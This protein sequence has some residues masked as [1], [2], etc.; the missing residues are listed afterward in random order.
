MHCRR[1]RR[2]LQLRSDDRLPFE[3]E[4]ALGVH[5]EACADCRAFEATLERIDETLARWPEPA[6]DRIDVDTALAAIHARIDA[7]APVAAAE[8]RPRRTAWLAA[9]AVLLALV[10]GVL[11]VRGTEQPESRTAELDPLT[12]REDHAKPA[13]DAAPTEEHAELAG[14]S[15]PERIDPERVRVAREFLLSTLASMGSQLAANATT[16]EARDFATSV[17]DALR[18]GGSWPWR[19][20]SERLLREDDPA[21]VRT[22]ARYVGIGADR[23]SIAALASALERVDCAASVALALRDAGAATHPAL[24]EALRDPLRAPAAFD[25]VSTATVAERVALLETAWRGFSTEARETALGRSVLEAL[26]AAGPESLTALIAGC[27]RGDVTEDQLVALLEDRAWA[28][29]EL[30][31]GAWRARRSASGELTLVLSARVAGEAALDALEHQLTSG[32]MHADALRALTI[33]GG[34]DAFA[35]LVLL[36]EAGRLEFDEADAALHAVAEADPDAPP[37]ALRL[38]AES[39]RESGNASFQLALAG[40]VLSLETSAAVPA[41]HL[42]AADPRFDPETRQAALLALGELGGL[43]DVDRL[44]EHFATFG[45][46]DRRLAAACLIALHGLDGDAAVERALVDANPRTLRSVLTALRRSKLRDRELSTH[47]LARALTPVLDER[48]IAQGRS[49]P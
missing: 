20:M 48:G 43:D 27:V 1:A 9:A 47:R 22:A 29:G 28:A 26:A 10:V 38:A 23:L 40:W 46:R 4:L 2:E 42:L 19:R 6:S 11:A 44:L 12:S 8:S 33:V 49:Q 39:A 24:A 36:H 37:L 41:L 34:P 15:P 35:R 5:L 14:P 31:D 7:D 16:D 17:D 13:V 30:I 32:E 18:A 21:L 3:R 45:A 25:A